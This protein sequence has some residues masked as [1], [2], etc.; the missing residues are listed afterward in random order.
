MSVS[1]AALLGR[2]SGSTPREPL[3]WEN[4]LAGTSCEGLNEEGEKYF[5]CFNESGGSCGDGKL[6][7]TVGESCRGVRTLDRTDQRNA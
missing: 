6:A 1:K 5:D 4:P 2:E 7:P 3:P